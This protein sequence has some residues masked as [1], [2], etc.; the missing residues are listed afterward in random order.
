MLIKITTARG[1]TNLYNLDN[2]FTI[3]PDG[4]GHI[5]IKRDDKQFDTIRV[6]DVDMFF[7][8]LIEAVKKGIKVFEWQETD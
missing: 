6:A 1:T 5:A 4:M 2:I 8:A 3:K 7:E